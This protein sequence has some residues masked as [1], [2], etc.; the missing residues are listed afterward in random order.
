MEIREAEFEEVEAFLY[1]SD[2]GNEYLTINKGLDGSRLKEIKEEAKDKEYH[3][4]TKKD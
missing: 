1:T 3:I 2:R 4:W